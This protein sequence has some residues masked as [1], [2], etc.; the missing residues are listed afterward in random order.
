MRLHTL[1]P[2]FHNSRFHKQHP[3]LQPYW[4]T[5]SEWWQGETDESRKR[6]WRKRRENNV[7]RNADL[8]GGRIID[9]KNPRLLHSLS[10]I[11][12]FLCEGQ[13]NMSLRA[14]LWPC[15]REGRALQTLAFLR[16]THWLTHKRAVSELS[17]LLTVLIVNSACLL[18]Q[19]KK[20]IFRLILYSQ[21]V[22]ACS[23]S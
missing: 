8:N 12:S 6:S 7:N 17:A 1:F 20:N 5:A 4:K 2:R 21:K 13:C 16:W 10:N 18:E 22:C 9:G 3:P 11:L 14:D 15:L 23:K 19:N